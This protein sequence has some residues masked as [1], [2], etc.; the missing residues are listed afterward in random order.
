MFR[1]KYARRYKQ[2]NNENN[3]G[4]GN[5]LTYVAVFT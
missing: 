4:M 3:N 2:E 1:Y 5:L